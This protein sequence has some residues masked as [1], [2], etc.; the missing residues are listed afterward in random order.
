MV[1]W[2][3]GSFSF[4][5]INYLGR[6]AYY[7]L[8]SLSLKSDL[9]EGCTNLACTL[10]ESSKEFSL[11]EKTLFIINSW[12]NLSYS[13]SNFYALECFEDNLGTLFEL[14]L[15]FDRRNEF[16]DYLIFCSSVTND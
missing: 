3:V 6:L 11:I 14:V 7:I 2:R 5:R 15:F 16:Y 10:G 4:V 13:Y 1:G 12:L 9:S 8:I